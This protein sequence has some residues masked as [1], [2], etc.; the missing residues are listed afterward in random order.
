LHSAAMVYVLESYPLM[1]GKINVRLSLS[2]AYSKA[3]AALAQ[4]RWKSASEALFCPTFYLER[5]ADVRS[6]W[7]KDPYLH[8]LM[9]GRFENRMPN[10]FLDLEFYERHMI[11]LASEA[12]FDTAFDHFKHLG[13]ALDL[14]PCATFDPVYYRNRYEP[15]SRTI[16]IYALEHFLTEG[17]FL[18]YFC[19]H[20]RYEQMGIP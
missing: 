12:N 2:S 5:H 17:I 11:P 4:V 15:V 7:C 10:P 13:S 19:T 16:I 20:P 9:Y 6:K 3:M 18:G 14:W 8:F 1:S